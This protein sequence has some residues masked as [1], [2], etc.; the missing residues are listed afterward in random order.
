[1]ICEPAFRYSS[2]VARYCLTHCR[3][4]QIRCMS[5]AWA[6]THGKRVRSLALRS[7]LHR[8]SE[9][10]HAS[11]MLPAA[12]GRVPVNCARPGPA[13]WVR[14][15]GAASPVPSAAVPCATGCGR[16]SGPVRARA[17]NIQTVP[18]CL[19]SVA[20]AGTLAG[21]GG[22]S[23]Q[24]G[25]RQCTRP[26]CPSSGNMRVSRLR[27]SDTMCVH[28]SCGRATCRQPIRPCALL[29]DVHQAGLGG[30]L[31][32]EI[33]PQRFYYPGLGDRTSV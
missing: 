14:S 23:L 22:S 30:I 19:A 12:I 6:A 24:A 18:A 9:P 27:P 10:Y 21:G 4:T 16:G 8:V 26:V 28:G 1:M 5:R 33:F 11:V 17:G 15:A 32:R 2:G 25:G 13:T 29:P 20:M 3:A 7:V 31:E